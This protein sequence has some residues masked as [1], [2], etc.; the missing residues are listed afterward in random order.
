MRLVRW[1]LAEDPGVVGDDGVLGVVDGLVAL[2]GDLA[3][4][5]F[6]DA[7]DGGAGLGGGGGATSVVGSA[8]VEEA[9]AAAG[10][11]SLFDEVL[12]GVEGDGFDG[13]VLEVDEVG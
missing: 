9:A 12:A 3:G 2:E 13:A 10:D 4:D 8:L 5:G 7:E 11:A 6:D 1:T